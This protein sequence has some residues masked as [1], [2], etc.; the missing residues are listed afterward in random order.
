MSLLTLKLSVVS[1]IHTILVILVLLTKY[2]NKIKFLNSINYLI[3]TSVFIFSFFYSLFNWLWIY[4]EVTT[5]FV[6]AAFLSICYIEL[7][8]YLEKHFWRD[9]LQNTLPFSLNFIVSLTLMVN[10]GYFTLLFILKILQS[11]SF[12]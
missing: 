11:K 4:D 3:L 2:K 7:A 9:F 6:N 10:A 8:I 12:F 5:Y 1:L